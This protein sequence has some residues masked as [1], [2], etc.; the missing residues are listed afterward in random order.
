MAFC[1]VCRRSKRYEYG[2]EKI[3]TLNKNLG[4]RLGCYFGREMCVLPHVIF[5]LFASSRFLLFR[6]AFLTIV[7]RSAV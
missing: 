4:R 6:D 2:R 5:L 7:Q 1:R 3:I